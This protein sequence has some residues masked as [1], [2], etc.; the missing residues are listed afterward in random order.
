MRCMRERFSFTAH[1]N[2]L[3]EHN[4]LSFFKRQP[5]LPCLFRSQIG[6]LWNDPRTILHVLLNVCVQIRS[7]VYFSMSVL[8][9]SICSL[10]LFERAFSTAVDA[11]N[12]T[13]SE[14][15]SFLRLIGHSAQPIHS[16]LTLNL[17]R[18]TLASANKWHAS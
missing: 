10:A 2:Q 8:S 3:N 12:C 11:A 18:N 9:T 17:E 16:S 14:C 4:N 5:C 6:N 1:N 13:C 7:A 15:F